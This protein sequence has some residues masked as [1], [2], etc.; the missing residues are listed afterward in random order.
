MRCKQSQGHRARADVACKQ[1]SPGVPGMQTVVQ[2]SR[3]RTGIVRAV[4]GLRQGVGRLSLTRFS[5]GLMVFV[6]LSGSEIQAP[7]AL[8]ILTGLVTSTALNMLVVPVLLARWGGDLPPPGR[9]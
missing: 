3:L 2:H 1:E 5:Y 4:L 9:D 8:V 7:M 6:P